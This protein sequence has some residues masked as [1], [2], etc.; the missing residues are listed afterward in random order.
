MAPRISLIA[1]VDTLGNMYA[2]FTQVNTDSKIMCL[3]V[4]ELVKVLDKEDADWRKTTVI[5]MD[6]AAYHVATETM[7]LFRT[8]KVPVLIM[9]PHSY[10]TAPCELLFAA[11]KSKQ[12]N[13]DGLPTGKK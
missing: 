1:G 8:L 6:G 11:I 3:F 7:A 9:G 4:R 13:P 2:A 12:L 5:T 10:S